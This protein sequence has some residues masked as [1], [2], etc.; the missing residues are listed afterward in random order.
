MNRLLNNR[1]SVLGDLGDFWYRQQAEDNPNGVQLARAIT[2]LLDGSNAVSKMGVSVQNLSG[3]MTAY[4]NN[5]THTFN[6][7]DVRILNFN[8]QKRY[9]TGTYP[10]ITITKPLK[11]SL[12]YT[13]A[14]QIEALGPTSD[15]ENIVTDLE[16]TLADNDYGNFWFELEDS[17][18]TILFSTDQARPLY[19]IPVPLNITPISITTKYRELTIGCSFRAGP[20]YILLFEDPVS[21]FPNNL[22][23]FRSV[24][25]SKSHTMDYTYQVDNIY[26]DGRYIA[27]YMR[28]THSASALRLAL[29]EVAGLPIL[30]SDSVL[31]Q[32]IS[33]YDCTIYE[34]D[35]QVITVPS[36]IEHTALTVGESYAAGTIFGEEYIKIYSASNVSDTPW[37]R[38]SDLDDVWSSDGL[39]LQNISPFSGV[40]V[41]DS[42]GSFAYNGATGGGTAH[43]YLSGT[44]ITGSNTSGYWNFV[45]YSEIYTDK[46][47]ADI[48]GVTYGATAN[49]IDFYFE[50]ML[51][52]N[53]LVIKLRTKELGSE[54]HSNVMSFLQRN[55]PI[56]TTPIILS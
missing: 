29:A 26:S 44:G 18:R 42:V 28:Q 30:F 32:V 36:F 41:K 40:I 19:F 15:P 56:N 49:C 25:Q 12:P 11:Y 24:L 20:G 43:Y 13:G 45:R 54:K 1:H 33:N 39:S 10:A 2:H 55:L 4:L 8:P 16:N 3:E 7:K 51:T 6:P 31:Q 22:I 21:L 14:L 9:L 53:S 17:D 47:L 46:F 23:T 52:Y 38:T 37:Y 35:S 5:V 34:F 27:A 50:N 48:P